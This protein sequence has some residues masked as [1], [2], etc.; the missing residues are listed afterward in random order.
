MS[1]RVNIKEVMCRDPRDDVG[2]QFLE[3]LFAQSEAKGC[4]INLSCGFA[5]R[6]CVSNAPSRVRG[7]GKVL[8]ETAER[9]GH[10]LGRCV[11][12]FQKSGVAFVVVAVK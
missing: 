1:V 12:T 8:E 5:T 7:V 9:F 2:R 6:R 4:P 3:H 11:E 10:C